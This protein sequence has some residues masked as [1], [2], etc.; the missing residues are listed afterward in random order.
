MVIEVDLEGAMYPVGIAA[1][2]TLGASLWEALRFRKFFK[3]LESS[4]E[5]VATGGSVKIL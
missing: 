5:K 1:P 3:K 2:P 4:V